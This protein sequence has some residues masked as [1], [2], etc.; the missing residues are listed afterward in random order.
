MKHYD[1]VGSF[2]SRLQT[3]LGVNLG[4]MTGGVIP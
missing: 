1:Q 3:W 2:L 4:K